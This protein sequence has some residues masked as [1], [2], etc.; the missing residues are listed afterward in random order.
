[1][2]KHTF[3]DNAVTLGRL[4][5]RSLKIFLKDKVG[6]FF[7]LLAPL[8]VLML[9]VLFLGDLQMDSIKAAFKD[10]PI[11]EKLLKNFVDGWM[12]AGVVSVACI[13]VSFSAQSIMV[14]DRQDGVLA[15]TLAS[16]V[17]RGVVAVGY[18]LSNVIISFCICLV[19]LAVA[20]VYLAITGWALSA[21]DVF[22]LIGLTAMSVFSAATLST[23]VCMLIKTSSQHSAFV[24]ITSALVGFFVGAYMPLSMFPKGVQYVTLFLP[25]TYSA[26]LYRNLFM[27]GSLQKI[28]DVV[29]QAEEGLRE[30]FSMQLDFFGKQIGADVQV[31]I[32]F[33]LIALTLGIWLAIEIA[34]AVKRAK[35]KE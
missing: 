27:R 3:A 5:E 18:L 25:G 17:S 21:G 31:W 24:G 6:V 11:D 29:P 30:S 4:V 10:V 9:Y 1:M 23:L 14:S 20:F 16:P 7:S 34:R 28:C 12:L 32:F 22:G 26:S 19:V 35:N 33:G 15:D 13:T 8:L 2:K